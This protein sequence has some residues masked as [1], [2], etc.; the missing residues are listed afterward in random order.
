MKKRFLNNSVFNKLYRIIKFNFIKLLRSSDGARKVSLGF[1]IGFGLEMLVIPTAYLMY[2]IFYPAVKLS[3]A[4]LS[5]AIIGNIIGKF[6][7]LPLLL[8]PFGK[9]IG[10][11]IFPVKI[12]NVHMHA[13]PLKDLFNGDLSVLKG[14]LYGGLQTL[15]GMAVFGLILGVISYHIIHYFYNKGKG[16]RKKKRET[17]Y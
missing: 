7:F 1:A 3:R 4:S 5:S 8:L 14:L 12:K 9:I 6:T 15:I 16:R 10:E 13:H 11:I 17:A 2:I